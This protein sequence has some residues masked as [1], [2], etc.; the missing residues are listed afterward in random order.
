MTTALDVSV[1]ATVL[2]LLRDVTVQEQSAILFVS[3]DLAV[4]RMIADR[5][6]VMKNG[7]IVEMGSVAEICET[8]KHAYTRT[9]LAAVLYTNV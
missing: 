7:E 3:H 6:I 5:I 1:Q 9:L 2:A 4:V 8:P